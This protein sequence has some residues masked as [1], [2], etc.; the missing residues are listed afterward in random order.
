MLSNCICILKSV[1]S[2]ILIVKP[3]IFVV[4]TLAEYILSYFFNHSVFYYKRNVIFP[5]VQKPCLYILNLS[6]FFPGISSPTLYKAIIQ[7]EVSQKEKDKY[8]LMHIYGI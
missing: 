5:R 2:T 4:F 6:P 3:D 8:T 7:N 1:S